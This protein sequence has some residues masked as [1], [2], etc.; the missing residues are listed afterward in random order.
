MLNHLCISGVN[1]I[2]HDV[3]ILLIHCWV[4]S[5]TVLFRV[6]ALTFSQVG[7]VWKVPLNIVCKWQRAVSELKC[8]SQEACVSS[9]ALRVPLCPTPYTLLL[10]LTEG[11]SHDQIPEAAAEDGS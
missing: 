5:A 11:G 4:Y 1:P 3:C 7:L 10:R 9:V 8:L 2:G 6:L